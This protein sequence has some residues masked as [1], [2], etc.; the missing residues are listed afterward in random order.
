M[1]LARQGT[2][3]P[4]PDE[5]HPLKVLIIDDDEVD[6]RA[7]RRMLIEIFGTYISLDWIS[8]WNAATKAFG[9]TN[10][11]VYLIDYFLGGRTGLELIESCDPADKPNVFIFLTGHDDREVDV[12]ATNAGASGYLV[13]SDINASTLER[14]IRYALYMAG[15]KEELQRETFAVKAAKD[16]VERQ[17]KMH[18]KLAGDLSATQ[19][20]LRAALKSAE[21]SEQKY[22]N[23]A[24]HDLLTELP[25]RVLFMSQLENMIEHSHRSEKSMALLLLD[26]DRFKS[27]NDSLGHPIGDRLLMQVAKRLTGC[28]RKTDTAARLGGDE[29]AVIATN[30]QSHQDTAIVA[31][32]IIKALSEPFEIEG[33]E[34]NTST[35]IGI[36]V[37]DQDS[38]SVESLLKNADAAL[39]KAKNDGRG[40]YHFFDAALNKQVRTLSLLKRELCEALSHDQFFLEYQPQIETSTSRVT[41]VEALVRWQHPTRGRVPPCD[42][43]PTAESTGQIAAMSEW[44]LLE[45]C[46]QAFHWAQLFG[47][48]IPVA[49]NLSAIQF[50]RGQLVENIARILRET[51]LP[52]AS[53]TLEITETVMIHDVDEVEMQLRELVALGVKIAIDDFGTGYSSLAHVR[54]LP[55]D[56]IKVDRSFVTDMLGNHRDAAVVEAVIA[57]G[58]NL[59]VTVVAEGVETREQMEYLRTMPSIDAQG[60]FIAKPMRPPQCQA[61]LSKHLRPDFTLPDP[62]VADPQAGGQVFYQTQ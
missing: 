41:G 51:G 31:Q 52:P 50:K 2:F 25:N 12:A 27:I 58:R 23:L 13:K 45:A 53:L 40:V 42:F 28:I 21:E 5:A 18:A 9:Q 57:L 49:V 39:Y 26:L 38:S 7:T 20:K 30:L 56:Q 47:C 54:Q 1:S 14:S 3:D 8:D 61:W 6:Y 32:H 55:I 22:R 36:A 59:G 44:I 17:S 4:S 11:D 24:Q 29:F 10:Y 43:I 34:I 48:G 15:K 16:V 37:L 19:E 46:K 60:Y 35:S 62:V 33:H